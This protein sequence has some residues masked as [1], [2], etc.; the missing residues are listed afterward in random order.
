MRYEIRE[1]ELSRP[2][3]PVRVAGDASGV[4]LIVRDAGRPVGFLMEPLPGGGELSAD[5]VSR[6]VGAACAD[7]LL[8]NRIR[9]ELRT[10]AEP[11]APPTVT[12][13]VCTKDRPKLVERLLA[14]LGPIRAEAA[15]RGVALEVLVVDNAPSDDA[16]RRAALGAG[17]RY[18][19]EPRPG[20]DFARNRAVAE[21][22][23]EW[24][25]FL[26][27]DV[28]V[29]RGW[30]AGLLEAVAENPDAGAVTGLVL[31]YELE[32]EAQVLFERRGGFRRGFAKLRYRGSEHPGQP[33]YPTGAGSFGAGANMAFRRGALVA[34]G[35]FDD[36]LDTGKPLPG[37]G[38]LDIFYRVIRGGWPLAY[39]PRMLVF[40]EHRRDL[41]GLRRQYG[42][43][44]RGFMAFVSKH[45]AADAE[46]RG[47]FGRIIAWWF[48]DQLR[49]LKR[50]LTGKHP[51]PPGM[52]LA[53]LW[54]GVAGLCGEYGRSRRR[55]EAIRRAHAH[56]AGGAPE[57]VVADAGATR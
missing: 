2:V 40:H 54:G 4:A 25:A 1:I 22:T 49:Q 11:A 27:D 47:R 37:G 50:S 35:G 14:S 16:T 45:R 55:V 12:I 10:K 18:A 32:T 57:G 48:E 30:L 8:Q 17:V 39:E 56:D 52:V 29:D 46:M 33:L 36:A 24:L 42:S 5:E 41:P 44:G 51:L 28:A 26:D 20:L 53:E 6:R 13:A 15:E 21:A 34:L 19:R 9:A 38:D 43:W 7:T 3:E 31:P 23:G